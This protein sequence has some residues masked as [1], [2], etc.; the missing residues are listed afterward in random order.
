MCFAGV[1][2]V[3]PPAPGGRAARPSPAKPRRP[4]RAPAPGSVAPA[5]VSSDAPAAPAA[6]PVP[7]ALGAIYDAGLAPERWPDALAAV[8]SALGASAATLHAPAAAGG[9]L[10]LSAASGLGGTALRGYSERFGAL[11]PIARAAADGGAWAAP[12]AARDAAGAGWEATAFFSGW[13]RPNGWGDVLCLGL[14]PPG[15]A[16][17]AAAV[18]AIRPAGAPP[19]GPAEVSVLL[20]L[21]P[22]L[23]RAAEVQRRL[24]AAGTTPAVAAAASLA[25]ALDS[26]AARLVLLDAGGVLVW[27]NRPAEALLRGG[28][29]LLLDRGGVLRAA[30]PAAGEAL[31]RLVGAAAAGTEGAM[32]LPRPSGRPALVLHAA[33]RTSGVLLLLNEPEGGAPHD[34]ALRRRLRAAYGLTPAEATVAAHAARGVGLPEVARSL[35][36]GV[37]TARTHAKRVF[38]KAGVRGQAELARQVERLSLLRSAAEGA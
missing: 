14:S 28:D 11:D 19:F 37:A 5:R 17:W 22:H 8:A 35:G 4:G 3:E 26:L 12:V 15:A 21:A 1:A 36:L 31:R 6:D 32:P 34:A 7:E 16:R 10:R 9:P 20:R 13:M 18:A 29:G 24:S 2:L 27:A 30:S 33:P 38:D 23:R 25:E